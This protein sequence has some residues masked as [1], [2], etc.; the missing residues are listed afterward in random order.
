MNSKVAVVIQCRLSSSRLPQKAV[1]QLGNKSVL[2]WVL[3]SMHKVKADRYFVATDDE[4]YEVLAPICKN[5]G[6]EIFKG[7]LNNVLKRFC[8]LL[9]EIKVDVIVRATADNPFLFYE[10]AEE[11][12][13]LMESYFN[14]NEACDYLTYSGLPHGSGVEIINAHSLLKAGTLTDDPYDKEHVGPAL[15][16][17]KENFECKFVPAPERFKRPELRSTIDTYS[18][19]LRAVRV[20]NYLGKEG[21][22]STEE[23][24]DALDSNYVKN[25]VIFVPSVKKGH[26]TGHLHR[27]LTAALNSKDYVYIPEDFSLEN[28]YS[29]IDEY[30]AKGLNKNQIINLLPDS[31]YEA[32]YIYDDFKTDKIFNNAKAVISIDE[33]LESC[34]GFDYLLDIIPSYDI[35]RK[36]NLEETSFIVKP[37]NKKEKTVSIFKKI[38]V[39]IGGED[40][41]GLSK[42]AA[43]NIKKLLPDAEVFAISKQEKFEEGVNYIFP[44]KNLREQ[45]FNYDLVITHYGLTAF[46]AV[47]AGCGVILLA[48]SKLHENLARKYNFAFVPFGKLDINSLSSALNSKNIFPES[49]FSM[50]EKS[51]GEFVRELSEGQKLYC[52][53]CGKNDLIDPVISR[54]NTRTYRKCSVCGMNYIS[55]SLIK[56]RKYEKSYFFNEYKKQYGK[57]YEDDFD[58]IKKT[59]ISRVKN[60]VSLLKDKTSNSIL[61]IGCAYGPFLDAA[62]DL[63]LIP[64]GTDISSDAVEYVNEKLSIPAV[65]A[66]FPDF[67]EKE[68]F[69]IEQ[70]DCCSMWYVIEHFKNLDVVLKKVN[71]MVKMNGIFAFSTPSGQGVSAKSN[72]DH[73]YQ[74]SPTDHFSVWDFKSAKIVM[75]KYGFK[76]EKIVSTGHHPERFPSINDHKKGSFYWKLIDF[77][78]HKKKLGDTME[79]YCRKI[80]DL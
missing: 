25:P 57:T 17:H 42:T 39:C 52:P 29:I 37:K 40:P 78:S 72:I 77:I 33:G 11:S 13:E 41:A 18:D 69:N 76:V 66:V 62:R 61:D 60:I 32:V 68:A 35:K 31:T 64:Y 3:S 49:N 34:D 30:V 38:L 65:T 70:F 59:G 56:D 15:Y 8:D 14:K 55:F 5:N 28:T 36:A 12:L 22:Y 44:V 16:N 21:P 67:S 79:V 26:G 19:Y 9:E 20:I 53:V 2:E 47:S 75:K 63:G 6:F 73:F 71:S 23:T 27:C 43:V 48:T 24:I 46:E 74:I 45:L 7:D 50:E 54:N 10:A 58:S 1:K 80:N 4:S 51:L